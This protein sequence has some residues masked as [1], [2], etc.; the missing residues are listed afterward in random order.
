MNQGIRDAIKEAGLKH[1]Q[2]AKLMGVSE[3]AICRWLR[4]DP[5]PEER[6]ARITQAIEDGKKMKEAK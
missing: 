3:A 5:M 6:Q 4:D 2:V 1:W